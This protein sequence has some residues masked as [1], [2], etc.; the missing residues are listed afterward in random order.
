MRIIKRLMRSIISLA[1]ILDILFIKFNKLYNIV[2]K[3]SYN[4][5]YLH[6]YNCRKNI[7][8]YVY[9]LLLLHTKLQHTQIR[10]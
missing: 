8:I 7:T 9:L 4:I 10:R 3:D 1:Y 5:M 6:T 2:D